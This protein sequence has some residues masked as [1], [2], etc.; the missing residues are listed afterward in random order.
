MDVP[1][2]DPLLPNPP[3]LRRDPPRASWRIRR[4][5]W[6]I[7][8]LALVAV[9]GWVGWP[10]TASGGPLTE[11]TIAVPRSPLSAPFYL[12]QI[13]G[14]FTAAGVRVT[15][16]ETDTGREALDLMQAG[17][18][19]LALAADTPVLKAAG[20]V[21]VLAVVGETADGLEIIARGDRGI[22]RVEDLPGH[23]V[24]WVPGTN[25]EY[26]LGG[27]LLLHGIPPG[28]LTRVA[29]P[30]RDAGQALSDG[31]I[32]ATVAW[33]PWTTKLLHQ[34]G[35]DAVRLSGD[36]IYVWQWLL[37]RRAD[38]GNPDLDRRFA[39]VLR[40]LIATEDELARESVRVRDETARRLEVSGDDLIACWP[41]FRFE[42]RLGQGLR[43]NLLNQARGLHL[44][45][46]GIGTLLDPRYLRRIDPDRV[47]LIS[48]DD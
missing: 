43:R 40:A 10:T 48:G 32:D 34:L 1:D 21:R 42:V 31:R 19:D 38:A 5:W 2:H 26:F 16:T 20:R 15:L 22:R 46:E 14:T 27:L 37:V 25:I 12:A 29:I 11:L 33:Q 28:A 18:A 3:P 47:D 17:Q 23:A 39:A 35:S 4:R 36:G 6:A 9:G 7:A 45:T 24:G 8:V 30:I 13:G 41:L 44:G